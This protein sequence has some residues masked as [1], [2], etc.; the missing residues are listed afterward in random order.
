M[1]GTISF[2]GLATG[3][4]AQDTVDKLI[5]VESRPKIL[6]EAEQTRLE[7]AKT[8]WQSANTKLL[9]LREVNRSI[10]SS[11][12][13]AT[14]NVSSTNE[15]VATATADSSAK[16]GTYT[17][18]VEKMALNGQ[19]ASQQ[20][21]SST[22]TTGTG[23][24]TLTVG[25]KTVDFTITESNNKLT[26]I[27]DA[28]N[29]AGL[30]A[31]ASVIKEGTKYRLLVSSSKTGVENNASL[32][33][34]VATSLSMISVQTAQDAVI[35]F[36]TDDPVSGSTALTITSATN[37]VEGVIQ[38]VTLNLVSASPGEAITLT[39]KRDT[40][41][42]EDAIQKFVD[43]YNDVL[44]YINDVTKYDGD[45]KTRSVLQADGNIRTIADRLRAALMESVNTGSTV[46]T[47]RAVGITL[48]DDGTLKFDADKASSVMKQDYDAVEKLFRGDNGV[49]ARV[50]KYLKDITAPL[51]GLVDRQQTSI[52]DSITAIKD[53][54]EEMQKR[55]D[56]HRESLL[57]KFTAMES[58]VNQFNT[59]GN[60]LASQ[61]SGL[62]KNW[63]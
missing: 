52:G 16:A 7:N 58:A 6:K 27:A 28:I 24:L 45:T 30:D 50:D 41:V 4:K 15:G 55:L 62:N 59:Q 18:S 10:W 42:V 29:D 32:S 26:D 33:G 40:T 46:R 43:A 54:I 49:G 44:G 53:R 38:G 35:K 14:L 22:S 51:T 34:D 1:A 12:T 57:E 2:D 11:K 48:K 36:G 61:L 60:F 56:T 31:T 47:L 17:F 5:E 3:I 25:T 13:W 39:S 63:A 20:Y 37:N 9:A 21:D 23:T 19:T 8:A